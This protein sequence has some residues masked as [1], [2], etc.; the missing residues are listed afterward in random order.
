MFSVRIRL[1]VIVALIILA[2]FVIFFFLPFVSRIAYGSST[3]FVFLIIANAIAIYYI[4]K[5]VF[6]KPTS[7][8]RKI[9]LAFITTVLIVTFVIGLIWGASMH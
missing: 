4:R 7:R 8:E 1:V 3:L 6:P 2:F 9:T 5:G